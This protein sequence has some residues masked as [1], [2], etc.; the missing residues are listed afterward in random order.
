M[1]QAVQMP[2]RS[3]EEVATVKITSAEGE[4]MVAS[5]LL[6]RDPR[7][8]YINRIFLLGS[9]AEMAK[10]MGFQDGLIKWELHNRIDWPLSDDPQHKH[11]RAGTGSLRS[12]GMASGVAIS[13]D[14]IQSVAEIEIFEAAETLA[15]SHAFP[16]E[17]EF[18]FLQRPHD[19]H[20]HS[21]AWSARDDAKQAGPWQRVKALGLRFRLL[22]I[23]YIRDDERLSQEM[24]RIR[25]PAVQIKPLDSAMGEEQFCE[26]VSRLWFHLKILIT[27]RYRQYVATLGEFIAKTR[28]HVSTWHSIEL[29]PRRR[30]RQ[31]DDPPFYGA[32]DRFFAQATKPL[33]ALEPHRELLH[34]A[35]FGYANSFNVGGIESGLTSCV[36]GIERLVTAF[37]K[38]R[39]LSGDLIDQGRW[40]KI[41]KR[42]KPQLATTDITDEE[43]VLVRRALSLP[44]RLTNL[45]RIQRMAAS[46][47]LG[48]DV[49]AK[50]LLDGADKMIEAR[51]AIVHGR[52]IDNAN[53]VYAE[54]LRARALFE[55]LFLGLLGCANLK[56]SGYPDWIISAHYDQQG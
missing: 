27:F 46:L 14:T 23:A 1:S 5:A 17:A 21:R 47:K 25:I 15:S 20:V 19:W 11:T 37:E 7:F 33:V 29:E 24:E 45:E 49:R 6:R 16:L 2:R 28:A 35:A 3:F 13:D 48:R 38:T 42:V 53:T 54:L 44:L 30:S 18:W 56:T 41:A 51:N 39:G 4:E 55:K 40:K 50:A 32:V 8:L 10:A 31:R 34:A 22:S 36:E 26:A 12:V 9:R 52:L 43:R